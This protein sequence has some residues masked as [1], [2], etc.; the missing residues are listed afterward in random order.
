MKSF[1]LIREF[2][3]LDR[4][5]FWDMYTG[6]KFLGDGNAFIARV[7]R[8]RDA[9]YP[10]CDGRIKHATKLE[11]VRRAHDAADDFLDQVCEV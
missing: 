3:G 4:A 2:I 1:R 11:R 5:G 9:T 7:A 6:E 10:A 8:F